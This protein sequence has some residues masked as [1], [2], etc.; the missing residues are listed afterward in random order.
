MKKL[1][2]RFWALLFY[3]L[4]CNVGNVIFFPV[5]FYAPFQTV[6]Q[7]TNT[8]IGN[9]TAAYASLA[10][11]AYLVSGIIADKVNSKLLMMISTISS[12]AVI[13]IMA[14]IPPY[15]VLLACFFVLSITLGLFFW[16]SSS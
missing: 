11:P 4:A 8:Q 12:T 15:P 10:I 14:I 9:L 3:G 1:G 2:N 13:F 5:M 6:F 16:S 7:L